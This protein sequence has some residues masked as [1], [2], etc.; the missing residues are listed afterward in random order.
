MGLGKT[1]Q[2]I[3]L[4]AYLAVYRGL[5]GPHLIVVPTSCLINWE[6]EFKRWCPAFKVLT[7]YGSAKARKALRI[8]WSK[9]N[10]F[11]V[12]ITSYQLV[13]QD[14]SAFRRKQWYYLILDEAHNIKNFKSQRWQTLLNF[15]TQ[16]RLLLTGTPLQNNLM[17]LWSLMHFLMPYIFRSRKEFSYWFNNPL[18]SM[19][20]G[21]RGI[22][23]DILSRLH[24][25]MRPFLLRRLKKDVAKQLPPKFEHI[26][27]CKLSKRQAFL[28]EEFMS[29]SATRNLMTGGNYLGMMNILMQLRKVCNHPDLFEPRA[30]VSPF[31]GEDMFFHVSALVSSACSSFP[32]ASLF[33]NQPNSRKGLAWTSFWAY[34][35][36]DVARSEVEF[37]AVLD[38]YSM[39]VG[40]TEDDEEDYLTGL[41]MSMRQSSAYRGVIANALTRIQEQK[42]QRKSYCLG[43]SS[44][45]CALENYIRFSWHTTHACT[46]APRF[47]DQVGQAK[48]AKGTSFRRL[49]HLERAKCNRKSR[50]ISPSWDGLI[51]SLKERA[52]SMLDVIKE[53]VFVLPTVISIGPQR[54]FTQYSAEAYIEQK[55]KQL[56]SASLRGI[57]EDYVAPFYP[58][59]IRQKIYFPDRKLVQ[60]DSG[61][62]QALHTLLDRLKKGGHKCLIFTQMSKMLD[63]LEIFLNLHAHTYV[64]LDGSTG[65][66]KR[67]RLMDRFN[68]DPKIFVFILSTRSGGLG[69]NLTGADTVI[70][71]DSD[72]NPAMDAQAQDRA[73][74]IGQTRE[75]HIYRMVSTSTVEEN[76]L[77][78]A[79]QKRHLDFLVMSEGDFNVGSIFTSNNIM[80]IIKSDKHAP[81][82]DTSAG[83]LDSVIE[84]NTAENEVNMEQAM[85]MVEDEDDAN[86]TKGAQAEAALEQAE[87]DESKALQEDS[88]L[89]DE[90]TTKIDSKEKGKKKGSKASS[91][92][93]TSDAVAI[94]E[95]EKAEEEFANWQAS[96]G[97]SD[98]Q[99]L[100][101]ALKP[102]ERFALRFH[103]DV[104]PFYSMHYLSEQQRLVEM[105]EDAKGQEWDIDAIEQQKEEEE[106]KALSQGELIAVNLTRREVSRVKV[107]YLAKKAKIRKDRQLRQLTGEGWHHYIDEVTG[108]PFWYNEDTG[109][110]SYGMPAV[111]KSNAVMRRALDRRFNA[112]PHP[113]LVKIFEYLL[114]Y[115]ER[116]A[117]SAVCAV[118]S[119]AARD[120]CFFKHVLSIETG[121]RER[122]KEREREKQEKT[123]TRSSSSA[124]ADGSG[125]DGKANVFVCLADALASALPGDT[126]ALGFGHHVEE[127]LTIDF[128]IRILGAEDEPVK[129]VLEVAG[130]L[131]VTPKARRVL[132]SGVSIQRSRLCTTPS[133]LLSVQAS[134]LEVYI[135]VSN[136]P[137]VLHVLI[138]CGGFLCFLRWQVV[139]LTM[140]AVWVAAYGLQS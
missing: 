5:W 33:L 99:K 136:Y 122:E 31:K 66:E 51:L 71:Y 37:L 45:R 116:T 30:I 115:P 121:A 67:Q 93:D 23:N 22:S 27:M 47:L 137:I 29:R 17:E 134:T 103:T 77:T 94:K 106:Y 82:V 36:D 25:I 20:E 18:T 96:V 91:S 13:V 133:S 61:K 24:G 87:F 117:C 130:G 10:A 19:V 138:H 118:W 68:T 9:Q 16:R 14:A 4:L 48:L 1:I 70:F 3:A 101:S 110:A 72:W 11:Q 109:E 127:S 83:D 26:V 40:M 21:N 52:D 128:P 38:D 79:K 57:V 111:I 12:C 53:F 95:E 7:Y 2:T 98:F 86:A 89:D 49:T 59:Y 64:R 105:E 124:S 6:L 8:G 63:I 55:Q 97:G 102:I 139:T 74:R 54:V 65:I 132:F 43:L 92:L 84:N 60:F 113:V 88:T 126:I 90:T 104:D 78:K 46:L 41:P 80:D 135:N 15:N 125:Q 85:A 32:C 56:V 42:V 73:H 107:E 39:D 69:I 131:H 81:P 119:T 50:F 129:V 44:K 100:E 76:I 62:L 112:C 28:Y 108:A 114:P 140:L 34:D 35:L 58:A 120:S 123:A 75:V